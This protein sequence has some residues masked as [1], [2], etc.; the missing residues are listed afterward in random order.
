M[1]NENSTNTTEAQ[2]KQSEKKG[3]QQYRLRCPK[4]MKLPRSVKIRAALM[5]ATQ[6]EKNYHMKTM[7]IAIHEANQK[8]RSANRAESNKAKNEAALTALE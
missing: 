3:Q 4:G 8:V 5:K 6:T 2:P 7:G 1:A